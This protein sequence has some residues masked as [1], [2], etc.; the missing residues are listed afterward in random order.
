M[1]RVAG[2]VAGQPLQR[3]AK[4]AIARS[5][6]VLRLGKRIAGV[7]TDDGCL[8]FTTA[9]SKQALGILVGQIGDGSDDAARSIRL[10]PALSNRPATRGAR[11]IAAGGGLSRPH[12]MPVAAVD[13]NLQSN[14]LPNSLRILHIMLLQ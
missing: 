6:E 5:K 12:R 10:P 3:R 8:Y 7:V 1:R 9:F 4:V 13:M 11:S 2:A 14:Q